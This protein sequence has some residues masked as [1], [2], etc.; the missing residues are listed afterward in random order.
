M[1]AAFLDPLL[2]NCE[3]FIHNSP[4]PI[5][6]WHS[7]IPAECP[8]RDLYSRRGLTPLI[9]IS[10]DHSHDAANELFVETH[11][12]DF[13]KTAILFDI[14]FQNLIENLVRWQRIRVQ[15]IRT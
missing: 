14:G 4:K 10:V 7:A 5:R 11:I 9:F 6:D 8:R 13:G 1:N 3:G 12:D 15:L 2:K